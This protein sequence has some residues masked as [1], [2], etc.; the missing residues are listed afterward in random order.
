MFKKIPFLIIILFAFINISH[1]A[2][3]NLT[4]SPTTGLLLFTSKLKNLAT[5]AIR[6]STNTTK[7]TFERYNAETSVTTVLR[8][9]AVASIVSIHQL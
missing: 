1:H 3:V 5:Y 8:T 6:D 7:W 2:L 4:T 9:M